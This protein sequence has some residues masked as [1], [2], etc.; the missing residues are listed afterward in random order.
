MGNRC[1]VLGHETLV[2]GNVTCAAIKIRTTLRRPT[3]PNVTCSMANPMAISSP[4]VEG[5]ES[6]IATDLRGTFVVALL[7]AVKA[8]RVLVVGELNPYGAQEW[9]ALYPYPEGSSGD[10]LRR[11]MGLS[12]QAY[13]Q[14]GRANLCIGIWSTSSAVVRCSALVNLYVKAS[15]DLTAASN[16][17]PKVDV[18]VAVVLLGAKVRDVFRGPSEFE[19]R[20]DLAG[21]RMVGLP[22][23]SGRCRAWNTPGAAQRTRD[24]LREAAPWIPWGSLKSEGAP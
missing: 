22:H 10:R 20:Y 5:V 4:R 14:L 6:R 3:T 17:V 12:V 19:V 16:A 15:V 2:G 18:P 1:L 8:S 11:M 21:I 9:A 24:L 23:P 13:K 7:D